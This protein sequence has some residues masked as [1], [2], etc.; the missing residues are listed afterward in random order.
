[1]KNND[2][3]LETAFKEAGYG[4]VKFQDVTLQPSQPQDWEKEFDE[5]F[6]HMTLMR[7]SHNRPLLYSTRFED[8]AELKAFITQLRE[9]AILQ[10]RERIKEE[11]KNLIWVD[12]CPGSKVADCE[13]HQGYNKACE[14]A[15][16]KI[17][18][19]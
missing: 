8:I 9:E 19:L 3:L 2:N 18:T 5:T 6:V 11:I 4:D 16:A 7:D 1:M 10:E 17:D 14:H 13:F 12:D 15:L